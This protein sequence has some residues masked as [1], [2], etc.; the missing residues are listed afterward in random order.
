MVVKILIA[1]DDM[2]VHQ[3]MCDVLAINFKK[4]NIE[5]ALNISSFWEKYSAD[6]AAWDLVFL[7]VKYILEEPEGF[8][9]RLTKANPD[10][11][12]KVILMGYEYNYKMCNDDVKAL[13]FLAKPFSLDRFAELAKSVYNSRLKV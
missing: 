6:D 1:D 4:V 5:R 3:L 13:P 8:M 10:T 9:E 7:R 11:L 12:N 2:D